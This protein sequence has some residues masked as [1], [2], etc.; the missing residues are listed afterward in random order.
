M[1]FL[2]GELITSV[3]RP[4]VELVVLMEAGIF[5]SGLGTMKNEEKWPK[6]RAK[7]ISCVSEFGH[8]DFQ[9]RD[10]R[11]QMQRQTYRAKGGLDGKRLWVKY[12]EICS[13]LR[14]LTAEFPPNLVSMPSGNQLHDVYLKFLVER[15]RKLF[16]SVHGVICQKRPLFLSFCFCFVRAR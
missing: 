4:L 12:G 8:G 7:Y 16:V 10:V 13:E 3:T 15:Y 9:S 1:H 5:I 11:G 6:M 14:R 2:R